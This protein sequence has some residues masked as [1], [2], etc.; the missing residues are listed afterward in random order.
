M[1]NNSSFKLI[2]T[3]GPASLNADFLNKA[4][5]ISQCFFRLNISHLTST[6]F[7]HYHNYVKNHFQEKPVTFYADL[8]GNKLRIGELSAHLHLK[9]GEQTVIIEAEISTEKEIPV[10]LKN[11]SKYLSKNDRVVLQDGL[12]E[13]IVTGKEKSRLTVTVTKGGTVRSRAGFVIQDKSLHEFRK[14]GNTFSYFETLKELAVEAVALS[15]VSHIKDIRNLKNFCNS[16][17]YRP[18]IIAKIEY[19]GVLECLEEVIREADSS[20]YCRGDLGTFLTAR[21]LSSWQDEFINLSNK[22]KKPA[23]IAGQVFH[24]LTF[25]ENPTR[26]EVVHFIQLIKEG[27]SGIVLSDETAVGNHPVNALEQLNNLLR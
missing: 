23:I 26:S 19:P 14:T 13:L 25:H 9:T 11:I 24:H 16:I 18:E 1:Q 22:N 12:V 15:Y 3:L 10:P 21:Q 7:R 2:S 4:L 27:V 6:Q 8:P 20:W 17:D 5:E